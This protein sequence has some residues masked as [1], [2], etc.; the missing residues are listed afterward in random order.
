MRPLWERGFFREPPAPFE[1][2][3][4]NMTY[5]VWPESRYLVRV[6]DQAP[7]LVAEVIMSVPSTENLFV[8]SDFLRAALKMP[9]A[10]AV[11][12]LQPLKD[13]LREPAI[14]AAHLYGDL[15]CQL[16]KGGEVDA[17][18]DLASALFEVLPD[19]DFSGPKSTWPRDDAAE[20]AVRCLKAQ[21]HGASDESGGEGPIYRKRE[22]RTR[23]D[24]GIYRHIMREVIPSLV[25][26]RPLRAV[27]LIAGL[28]RDALSFSGRPGNNFL[29]SQS[30]IWHSDITQ[31]VEDSYYNLTSFLVSATVHTAT[32]ALKQETAKA[33]DIVNIFYKDSSLVFKRVALHLLRIYPE[34]QEVLI[35]DMLTNATLLGNFDYFREYRDLLQNHFAGMTNAAKQKVLRLI[36][37][38]PATG[39]RDKES[40]EVSKRWRLQRLYL[41]SDSLPEEW[42]RQAED[43]LAEYGQPTYL[44]FGVHVGLVGRKS[45]LT[46]ADLEAMTDEELTDVLNTWIPTGKWDTPTR[47]GLG[48]ELRKCVEQEPERWSA[49]ARVF[50]D[51]DPTYVRNFLAGLTAALDG[52]KQFEWTAVL[53]L[54]LWAADMHGKVEEAKRDSFDADPEWSWTH[55]EIARLL[56]KAWEKQAIAE[57]LRNEVWSIL[58]R[59]IESE[60]P[61]PERENKEET[62]TWGYHHV[63]IN[64]SRG[65]AIDAL[66][67]Y[68]L[69]RHRTLRDSQDWEPDGQSTFRQLGEERTR[70]LLEKHLAPAIDPSSAIRS[71][72]GEWLLQLY[73]VDAEWLRK[74]LG[75]IFPEDERLWLGAW[76][77]YVYYT[78]V[79]V[80]LFRIMRPQY[81]RAI[82]RLKQPC[83]ETRIRDD[84]TK[85]LAQRLT[86]VLPIVKT[87]KGLE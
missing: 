83:E 1:D 11:T 77:G 68:L 85:H 14:F 40:P 29:D 20:M 19:P 26:T 87:K 81:K 12:L 45:P 38:G 64:S 47:A 67:R 71:V 10:Q 76:E 78:K 57:V 36:D 4:G 74:K 49:R 18:F 51:K 72:Y 42:K 17:A 70:A 32:L 48:E 73:F 24:V 44:D 75:D 69:W 7:E 60:D 86:E 63:A 37:N 80:D 62:G 6:A 22:P 41:I 21:G 55:H 43:L 27:T 15:V 54:C 52:G 56:S 53:P 31:S 5:P 84:M 79:H 9:P 33:I 34:G 58:E 66:M 25:Q 46:Q 23:I 35:E 8:Y 61:T 13:W 3:D 39:N 65:A 59:L 82:R 30:H 16:A 28:L 50:L 2:G